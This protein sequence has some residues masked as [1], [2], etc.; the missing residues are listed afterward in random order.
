MCLLEYLAGIMQYG[1]AATY[2][3]KQPTNQNRGSSQTRTAN[4]SLFSS[5]QRYSVDVISI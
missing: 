4:I 5:L 1:F 3:N 2:N